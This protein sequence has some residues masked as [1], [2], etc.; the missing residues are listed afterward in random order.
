MTLL[1]TCSCFR[2]HDSCI[3]YASVLKGSAD[4]LNKKREPVIHPIKYL[5]PVELSLTHEYKIPL[6]PVDNLPVESAPDPDVSEDSIIDPDV[7][8]SAIVSAES[9][10][11]SPVLI[12]QRGTH[13][14]PC[15]MLLCKL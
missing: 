10:S 3:R 11:V 15:S 7:Q 8:G 1:V 9:D 5:Y 2:C 14:T 12:S 13:I 6:S 4:Y